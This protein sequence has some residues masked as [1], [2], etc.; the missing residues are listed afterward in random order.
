MCSIKIFI[1]NFFLYM[2]LN[3]VVFPA[4]TPH[5]AI[6][7]S[8][9]AIGGSSTTLVK[10]EKPSYL[11]LLFQQRQLPPDRRYTYIFVISILNFNMCLNICRMGV[12]GTVPST[13]TVHPTTTS[14]APSNKIH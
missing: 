9:F 12:P 2:L 5:H 3:Y 8:V 4:A 1:H 7:K 13:F 11:M 6:P 10:I 14:H